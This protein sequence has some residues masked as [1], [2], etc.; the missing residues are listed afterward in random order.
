MFQ[1]LFHQCNG[2]ICLYHKK[3]NLYGGKIASGA[4]GI[5]VVDFALYR[6]SFDPLRIIVI[7]QCFVR[8]RIK[9]GIRGQE[10]RRCRCYERQ[11]G[12][13]IEVPHTLG[14]GGRSCP[15][16]SKGKGGGEGLKS[17]LV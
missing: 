15:N 7:V 4:F 3:D 9:G 2:M 12:E 13:E 17:T 10:G 16:V 6:I 1:H 8:E 14:G 5:F 11:R